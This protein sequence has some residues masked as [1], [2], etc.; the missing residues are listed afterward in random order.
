MQRHRFAEAGYDASKVRALQQPV[1]L[2]VKGL[3][4][5]NKQTGQIEDAADEQRMANFFLPAIL[6]ALMFMVIMVGATPAMQGIV[7]EKGQR[8]AEVLL[9]SVT[10]FQLM[11]GKLLGVVGVSLTMAAVY[12]AGGLFVAHR[13][14][15]T[16]ALTP[17]LVVWFLRLPGAGTV[18]LRVAVHRR[19]GRGRRHQ[20]HADAAHA[21]HAGRVPAVL[22]PGADHDGPER[23]G[24]ASRARS[25]RSPR[26]CSW[27][28]GKSVPPGVPTW[29]M[30]TGSRIV[31]ATTVFC[32]W[33]AGRI[34][35]VGILMQG[36]GAKVKDMVQWVI[37]G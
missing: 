14:G 4:R 29:Q 26:R 31:L 5:E 1:P 24:R 9:G 6:I 17:A 21:D 7:E 25:S 27:S 11:A 3:T 33:A 37:R 18:D 20:G 32:V 15:L 34:F 10:P 8:I 22:R 12:L 23:Q 35:R 19:R 30:A 16:D 36:K 13:Y 2:K 28:P